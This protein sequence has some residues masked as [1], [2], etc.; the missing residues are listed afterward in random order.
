MAT[1]FFD[2]TLFRGLFPAYASP[3]TFPD[4]LLQL[5]WDL[6]TGYITNNTVVACY[7]GMRQPQQVNALNL[8]TAHLLALNIAAASGQPSGLVQGATIDKVSVQLTPP[9]EVSQW[10]WW[11]NQTP[12]GQQLLALLQIASA[13]GYFFTAGS[14]VVPAFRR[15]GYRWR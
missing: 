8:M 9:P 6:A 13:G 10:Q 14:P 11:L 4:V 3:V 15:T 12:Y 2:S 5:Q 7:D 1:V